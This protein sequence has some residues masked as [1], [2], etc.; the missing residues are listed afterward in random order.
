MGFVCVGRVGVG[1]V[2]VVVVGGGYSCSRSSSS[3]HYEN[4]SYDR[5]QYRIKFPLQNR[6]RN[7]LDIPMYVGCGG[8]SLEDEW[9]SEVR[10][11]MSK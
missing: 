5:F 9:M 7:S 3:S 8:S 11:E 6:K 4:E 1:V 10:D 2:V